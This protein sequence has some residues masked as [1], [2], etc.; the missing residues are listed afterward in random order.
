L[1][2]PRVIAL[3]LCLGLAGAVWAQDEPDDEITVDLT[4][5]YNSAYRE[6][7]WVPVDV[8]V[9]NDAYD[10]SG[11]IEVRIYDAMEQ[12]TSP[13][14]RVPAESPKAS[15]KRFRLYCALGFANRLE[16]QLYDN[17][18]AA[19]PFPAYY[20]NA[21]AIDPSD[22][23]A[24]VLTEEPSDFGFLYRIVGAGDDERRVHRENLGTEELGALADF[25]QCYDP[26]NVV[27]LGDI[28][29]SR[30]AE[31]H[32]RLLRDY[33][34]AGGVLVVCTGVNARAYRGSWV[35]DLAG[36]AIG[37]TETIKESDLAA[38]VFGEDG[39]R[40]AKEWRECL[41]AEFHSR[42]VLR[43]QLGKD[44]TLAA[45]KPLG[46]G[47]VATLG[48]DGMSRALQNCP[49]YLALWEYLM[50][51][52]DSSERFNLGAATEVCADA[53][54]LLSGIK[55]ASRWTVL[56]Y[57][58]AYFVV[59]IA[60]NWAACSLLKRRE[61]FWVFL[62]LFSL[63]FT[64]YAVAF[65][66]VGLA[67]GTEI[68]QVNVVALP[69]NARGGAL[70]SIIGILPRPTSYFAL[71]LDREFALIRDVRAIGS[72]RGRD[73]ATSERPF[74]AT[75]ASPANV[76]G[77]RVKSGT[78]RFILAESPVRLN[79]G[80]SGKLIY[81]AD[82]LNGTLRNETGLRLDNPFLVMNGQFCRVKRS[83]DDFDVSVSPHE[84]DSLTDE[85]NGWTRFSRGGTARWRPGRYYSDMHLGQFREGF[86][87]TLFSSWQTPGRFGAPNVGGGESVRRTHGAYLCGWLKGSVATDPTLDKPAAKKINET[88]LVAEVEIETRF[89]TDEWTSLV[90][91]PAEQRGGKAVPL[92]LA[93][94]EPNGF[95]VSV[96]PW[97]L[98]GSGG[99]IAIDI[100]WRPKQDYALC[101]ALNERTAEKTVKWSAKEPESTDARQEDEGEIVKITYR[102]T[103][104]GD[105]YDEQQGVVRG[106]LWA[107]QTGTEAPC[108]NDGLL[109]AGGSGRARWQGRSSGW[110][111]GLRVDDERVAGTFMV[112]ARGRVSGG[113][114]RNAVGGF[115]IWR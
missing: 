39:T 98:P 2:A 33:V 24:L 102:I 76:T 50:T 44:K 71:E 67:G 82:G 26:F 57:L 38:A 96:P 77:F 4:V 46:R 74:T 12:L 73:R 110:Q 63:G 113:H 115:S 55:I 37:A 18:R 40:G 69:R 103:D 65:G 34:E 91:Q 61:L 16:A 58:L 83:R 114:K 85:Y 22:L 47:F 81:D 42:R 60:L 11:H 87:W 3:I 88:L 6:G 29:P 111:R 101:L 59:G 30:I 105:V 13:I 48:V 112:S 84:L 100:E 95:A 1:P 31:R 52:R 106:Q 72:V 36:V 25:P 7:A 107:Y 19:T 86:A 66:T 70:H 35:E 75:Q 97:L 49:G 94:F 14:Y 41:L 10:V 79:G 56:T 92:P 23:M 8:F 108:E 51:V 78:M 9:K 109:G 90:V 43:Q 5:H 62:V 64:A 17:G 20:D 99:E 15:R 93:L 21:R 80:I 32:R 68:E 28:D 54:P 27:I 89:D 53:L 104:I 45:L